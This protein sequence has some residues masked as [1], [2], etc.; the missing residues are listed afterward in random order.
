MSEM[1]LIFDIKQ[2][3]VFDG[4]GIRTT[5]FLKGCPMRCQ[6]C[7]NPEGISFHPQLMISTSSCIHC[8]RCSLVCNHP[9]KCIACGVCVDVCPLHLRRISGTYYTALELAELLLRDKDFLIMNQGGITLSGGEPL[10]Q[11]KFLHELLDYLSEIHTAIETSGY[12]SSEI[13]KSI[14]TKVDYVMMDIK[15]KDRKLHRKYTGVD[16]EIILQNLEYLKSCCKEFA[17]R[18]PL[19]PGVN[20]TNENLTQTA[21]LLKGV[22]SLTKVELLPYHKTA[23]AKYGMLGMKYNPDFDVESTPNCNKEIFE[24][25]DIPCEVL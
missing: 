5:V 14:I 25:F 15:M 20:D 11:P 24:N 3:A 8:G 16:N 9:K 13:F 18:I 2:F 22:K 19:I 17:I 1:G 6:W 10:A 4:P 7:H 21:M 23:G 12:C